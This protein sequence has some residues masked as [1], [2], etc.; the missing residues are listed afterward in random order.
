MATT[1]QL[2]EELMATFHTLGIADPP[3]ELHVLDVPGADRY[4]RVSRMII[5]RLQLLAAHTLRGR[6]NAAALIGEAESLNELQEFLRERDL[7]QDQIDQQAWRL[8][9]ELSRKVSVQVKPKHDLFTPIEEQERMLREEVLF[10]QSEVVE[11]STPAE[12]KRAPGRA[13]CPTIK[14]QRV[15]ALQELPK[16]FYVC[17]AGRRKIKRLHLLHQCWMVPGVD[18]F[19]LQ[20]CRQI[21]ASSNRL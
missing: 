21:H 11:E 5:Q 19:C 6:P 13:P 20:L 1:G 10:H 14:E 9:S 17:T 4:V 3:L 12:P 18:Y 8:N 7:P 16:G 2:F 15:Q